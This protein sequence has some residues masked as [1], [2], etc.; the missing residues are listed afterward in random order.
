MLVLPPTLP[1][2]TRAL[3]TGATGVAGIPRAVTVAGA[4]GSKKSGNEGR[5][6]LTPPW[7]LLSWPGLPPGPA[8]ASW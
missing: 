8:T 7:M 5:A 6:M 2:K 4:G 1:A 3:I